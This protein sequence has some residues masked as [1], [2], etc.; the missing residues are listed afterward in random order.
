VRPLVSEVKRIAPRQKESAFSKK[1]N[2][3]NLT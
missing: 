3:G 1:L 2:L